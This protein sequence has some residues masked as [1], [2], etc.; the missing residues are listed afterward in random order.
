MLQAAQVKLLAVIAGILL[1]ILGLVAYEHR[2]AERERQRIEQQ[3][4]AEEQF[5]KDL[6]RQEQDPRNHMQSN[7]SK[8]LK[9]H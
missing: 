4:Q 2:Q 5:K 1:A 8:F 6:L 3:R 7:Q 9:E